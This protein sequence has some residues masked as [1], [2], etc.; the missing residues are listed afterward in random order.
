MVSVGELT[1]TLVHSIRAGAMKGPQ[2]DEPGRKQASVFPHGQMA[3]C[4]PSWD[5]GWYLV[6]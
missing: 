1:A 3:E 6:P 5:G 4:T 2:A